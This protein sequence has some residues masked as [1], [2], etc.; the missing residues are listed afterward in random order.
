MMIKFIWGCAVGSILCIAGLGSKTINAEVE[1]NPQDLRLNQLQTIGTHNSYHLKPAPNLSKVLLEGNWLA[2]VLLGTFE[3][4]HSPL[5]EQFDMGVRQIELDMLLDPEG[6]LYANPFGD[7]V[8]AKSGLPADPDFDPNNE[9]EQPGLKIIHMQDIDYRSVC[10]TF[11]KCLQEMKAWSDNNPQHL[12][13]VVLIEAKDKAYPRIVAPGK[14]PLDFAKPIKFDSENIGEIDREINAVFSKEQLITPDDV[15]GSYSTLRQAIKNDGWMRVSD[16]RGKIIFLMDNRNELYLKKYPGLRGATLFT[17][18]KEPGEN[19]AI[20]INTNEPR[21][22]IPDLV[23]QGYI[24][25]TRADGDTLQARV[26]STELKDKAIKS[27][28]QYISTDFPN[29]NEYFSDFQV[30]FPGDR[31]IRCNPINTNDSCEVRDSE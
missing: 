15:R 16:A 31:L 13:I 27:G 26:G 10:L 11:T 17:T 3:Y 19:D 23:K 2:R 4:S 30:L 21:K 1:L 22:D 28:A 5:L 18:A 12:P 6:G 29:P 7:S 25:R 14:E 20:F 8:V 9:M 24:V